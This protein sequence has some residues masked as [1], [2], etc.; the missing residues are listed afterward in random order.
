MVSAKVDGKS[1][2]VKYGEGWEDYLNHQ[3]YPEFRELLKELSDKLARASEP[4]K[5]VG[6]G[7]APGMGK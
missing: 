1:F 6:K 3:E 5:G 4:T 2:C 7:K